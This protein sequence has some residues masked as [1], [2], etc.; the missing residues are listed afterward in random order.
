MPKEI[1]E[2][3]GNCQYFQPLED[4]SKDPFIPGKCTNPNLRYPKTLAGWTPYEAALSNNRADILRQLEGEPSCFKSSSVRFFNLNIDGE[5]LAIG[6]G[7]P[8]PPDKLD[9]LKSA[10]EALWRQQEANKKRYLDDSKN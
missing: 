1:M 3:C 10:I 4:D 9:D 7:K 6:T 2:V 8:I 5:Q